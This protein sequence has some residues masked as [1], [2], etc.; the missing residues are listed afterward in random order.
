ML[1]RPKRKQVLETV[2]A[3]VVHDLCASSAAQASRCVVGPNI[4]NMLL[5]R[6]QHVGHMICACL[7]RHCHATQ[8]THVSITP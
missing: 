4:A 2:S 3:K 8:P 1:K 5:S 7:C 6:S